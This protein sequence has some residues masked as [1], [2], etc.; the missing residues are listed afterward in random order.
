MSDDDQTTEPAEAPDTPSREA[1]RYRRQLRETEAQRDQLL[2]EL[3]GYR[4]Q[5][6]DA[7]VAAEFPAPV[8][9]FRDTD[10]PELR[11]WYIDNQGGVPYLGPHK[12]THP[13]D[14]Y[15]IGGVDRASLTTEDGQ[16]DEDKVRAALE[17]LFKQRP[18]LFKSVG[19][20]VVPQL[21]HQPENPKALPASWESIINGR[22][23]Q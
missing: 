8:R 3:S 9:G 22:N 20:G 12:L 4:A 16:P 15:T 6:V 18:E 13:E 11:Q 17:G 10:T 2:D 7:L 21:G 14:L 19:S 5:A 1:A 23:N